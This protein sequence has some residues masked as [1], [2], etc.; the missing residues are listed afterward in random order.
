MARDLHETG[1]VR[2]TDDDAP[3]PPQL[4]RFRL[5]VSLLMVVMM[6]GILSIAGAL[7]WKL[8]RSES[9]SLAPPIAGEIAIAEGFTVISVSRAGSALYLLLEHTETGERLI[10]QRRA[11]DR[12]VV[13]QYRLVPMNSP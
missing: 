9:V 3:E 8:T 2:D 7:V 5:L 11:T 10:E 1:A 4:R 6:V 12:S 13:G